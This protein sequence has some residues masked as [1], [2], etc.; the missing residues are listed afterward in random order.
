MNTLP[1][2]SSQLLLNQ[3]HGKPIR[4]TT[5]QHPTHPACISWSSASPF[6]TARPNK[7]Q[8]TDSPQTSLDH[9]FHGFPEAFVQW[10]MEYGVAPSVKNQLIAS[11]GYRE[12]V[13]PIDPT[14]PISTSLSFNSSLEQKRSPICSE[15]HS[16]H[17]LST[18]L[19][20]KTTNPARR[21]LPKGNYLINL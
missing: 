21:D 6:S 5:I 9:R 14:I 1:L 8:T 15:S 10:I 3:T 11:L 4:P 16:T 17:G 2:P 19:V 7:H 12:G 13:L 20:G 18:M